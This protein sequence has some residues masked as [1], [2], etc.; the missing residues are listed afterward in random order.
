MQEDLDHSNDNDFGAREKGEEDDDWR[1]VVDMGEDPG[2]FN[3]VVLYI[4]VLVRIRVNSDEER[5]LSMI[6]SVSES[7]VGCV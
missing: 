1:I 5:R 6:C 3:E 2:D 4:R 7:L